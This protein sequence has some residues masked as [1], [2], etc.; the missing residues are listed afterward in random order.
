MTLTIGVIEGGKHANTRVIT[1]FFFR[2]AQQVASDRA[3]DVICEQPEVNVVFYVAGDLSQADFHG[4]RVVGYSHEHQVVLV[5]VACDPSTLSSAEAIGLFIESSIP[6]IVR[7]SQDCFEE[8]G[9]STFSD[10]DHARL[11]STVV[12][13]VVNQQHSHS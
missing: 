4:V 5:H 6:D 9:L 7:L 11:L 2:L 8:H 10:V 13:T 12:K 1:P 3:T